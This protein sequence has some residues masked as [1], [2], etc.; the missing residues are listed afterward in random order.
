MDPAANQTMPNNDEME[1]VRHA[2]EEEDI[3]GQWLQNAQT[4][5]E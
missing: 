3:I 1:E 2:L 4:E 5:A